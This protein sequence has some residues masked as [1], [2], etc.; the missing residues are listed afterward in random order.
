[1]DE[2]NRILY[3][4]VISGRLSFASI[5]EEEV[6]V[7]RNGGFKE[8]RFLNEISDEDPSD[9]EQV[10]MS[11]EENDTEILITRN[12]VKSLYKMNIKDIGGA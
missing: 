7:Y 6:D 11:W 10:E 5:T 1:M 8:A 9:E 2:E 4:K 12:V 3:T